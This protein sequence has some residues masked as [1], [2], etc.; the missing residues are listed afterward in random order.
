V[1][2]PLIKRENFSVTLETEGEIRIVLCDTE[3]TTGTTR[4]EIKSVEVKEKSGNFPISIPIVPID[5]IGSIEQENGN[6]ILSTGGGDSDDSKFKKWLPLPI[7]PLMTEGSGALFSVSPGDYE[8]SCFILTTESDI[9]RDSLFV[10]TDKNEVVEVCDRRQAIIQETKTR[11]SSGSISKTFSTNGKFSVIGADTGSKSG[12]SYFHITG[13]KRLQSLPLLWNFNDGPAD[14][15]LTIYLDSS[16]EPLEIRVES[17][18]G[19]LTLWAEYD[20]SFSDPSKFTVNGISMGRDIL[21]LSCVDSFNLAVESREGLVR[22]SA[23]FREM[24]DLRQRLENQE[25]ESI[26]A[27]NDFSFEFANYTILI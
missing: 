23:S 8:V 7:P 16:L 9:E 4:I 13:L 19:L 26:L 15:E 6:L 3:T 24:S 1:N 5:L 18:P 14:K 21:V 11:Y 27:E 20:G 10:C 2:V 22:L 12:S 17:E 25:L